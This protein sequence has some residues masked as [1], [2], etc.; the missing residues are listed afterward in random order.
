MH[1]VLILE[2][3]MYLPLFIT[4]ESLFVYTVSILLKSEKSDCYLLNSKYFTT[5]AIPFYSNVKITGSN[6]A[7]PL[8]V[9]EYNKFY[10]NY[11]YHD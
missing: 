2:R 4:P 11:K 8:A 10:K 6:F 3:K 9:D 5:F 7:K 1:S